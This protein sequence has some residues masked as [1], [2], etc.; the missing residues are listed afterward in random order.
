MKIDPEKQQ[1]AWE[2]L[3]ARAEWITA[4][5][6][7]AIRRV[8]TGADVDFVFELPDST[9]SV[10]LEMATSQQQFR[11]R[12]YSETGYMVPNQTAATWDE[13]CMLFY[14]AAGEEQVNDRRNGEAID[15]LLEFFERGTNKE[16]AEDEE[17]EK[18]LLE[19]IKAGTLKA[20]RNQQGE[21]C[22][23]LA[24]LTAHA[25]RHGVPITRPQLVMALHDLG[26]E[27][28]RSKVVRLWN[29]PPNWDGA[30]E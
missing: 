17:A 1:K 3:P 11:K 30:N 5:Q 6:L 9:F 24:E 15:L 26:F 23:K 27:Q 12:V 28:N 22:F 14:L 7:Q 4:I 19:Q 29:S 20:F 21:W 18:L 16:K 8:R 2:T 10:P 25:R 13:T